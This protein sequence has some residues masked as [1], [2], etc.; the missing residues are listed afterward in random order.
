MTGPVHGYPLGTTDDA[1]LC[2]LTPALPQ[3]VGRR[4]ALFKRRLTPRT[5]AT[6][7]PPL[8]LRVPEILRKQA[9]GQASKQ[10]GGQVGEWVGGSA[11]CETERPFYDVFIMIDRSRRGRIT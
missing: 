9:S 1:R 2:H 5:E 8:R 7:H 4:A 3:S 11:A 6:R 10:A